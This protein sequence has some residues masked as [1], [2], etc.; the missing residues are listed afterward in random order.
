ME[1]V[2]GAEKLMTR[3]NGFMCHCMFAYVCLTV[4]F[5]FSVRRTLKA[6]VVAKFQLHIKY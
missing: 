1:R 4:F 5:F 2:A 3:S 6:E